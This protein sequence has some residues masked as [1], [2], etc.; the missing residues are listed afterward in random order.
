MLFLHPNEIIHAIRQI[1]ELNLEYTLYGGDTFSVDSIYKEIPK[2]AEGIVFTLPANPDSPEFQAFAK[3][4]QERFSERPDINAAVGYDAVKLLAMV[5]AEAQSSGVTIQGKM[6]SV[7]AYK[8]ASG[9]ITFNANGD[10][11]SKKYDVMIIRDG[12]YARR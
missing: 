2:L 10:V 1:R 3:A 11:I 4:Y 12:K 5:A 9:E 6:A 8:G 7:K